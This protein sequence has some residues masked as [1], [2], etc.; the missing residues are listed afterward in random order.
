MMWA[1]GII[2]SDSFR[3][4]SSG[5]D[6]LI[7]EESLIVIVTGNLGT[8]ILTEKTNIQLPIQTRR[9]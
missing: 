6:I 4:T 3:F 2:L 5:E 8:L 7:L 9:L 1:K